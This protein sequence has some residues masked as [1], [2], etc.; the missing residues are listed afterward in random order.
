MTWLTYLLIAGLITFALLRSRRTKE[1][2]VLIE[3][4]VTFWVLLDREYQAM[5][6]VF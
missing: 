6:P 5:E 4:T 2:E 1:E 3:V